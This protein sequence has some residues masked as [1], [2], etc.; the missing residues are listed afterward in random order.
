MMTPRSLPLF[1]LLSAI[2][3]ACGCCLSDERQQDASARDSREGLVRMEVEPL[4]FAD[5]TRTAMEVDEET[6]LHFTWSEGDKTGVYSSLG[7]FSLFRLESGA[8]TAVARFDGAGFD[9]SDGQTYRAFYPYS[10]AST[11]SEAIALDY[12]G[13]H[14]DS[15]DDRVSP[16]AY[17][18][19]YASAT[20]REGHAAFHFSHVGAFVRLRMT[21][22]EGLP[23][24][25]IDWVPMM[26]GLPGSGTFNLEDGRFTPDGA[27]VLF[28][29]TAGEG[30]TVPQGGVLTVWTVL[31]PADYT[32]ED[33]AVFVRSGTDI[34]FTAR[35]PGGRFASGKAARWSGAPLSL[36]AT[37]E[38]GWTVTDRG[39][40]TLSVTSG[41]YSGITWISGNRYAVVHDKL[42]GGGIT[43]F[44]IPISG[45]GTVGTVT[46]EKAPGTASAT[47]ASKDAEGIAWDGD[48]LFV[49][50]EKDQSISEYALE[51]LPTG[52]ALSIP[53]DM[54][55]AGLTSSNG[56][57]EALSYNAVTGR[58][59]TTTE[60]PLKKDSFLSRLHRLQSFNDELGPTQRYL[61][62]MDAPAKAS[63][64]SGATYVHGISALTALDDGRLVVL[65][66]EVYVPPRTG[67]ESIWELLSIASNAF[68]NT[69]LYLVD[70]SGDTAGIL[71]KSLLTSF[72]TNGFN[73]ANYEG[74]CLGPTLGD[75]SRCLVLI[76]DSQGGMGGLTSEYIR[77]VTLR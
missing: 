65:E 35:V 18:Y 21:L 72:S 43:F 64:E 73:L 46:M 61:Y 28:P 67:N 14:F 66:R 31:P 6:G 50:F 15:D 77:V 13:Q 76:P 22:P 68:A 36:D 58:F 75:G 70:P 48:H 44:T 45:N 38:H 8:G 7:G 32:A 69:K 19:L 56:G 25:G 17:D 42:K 54:G 63:V 24:S 16:M 62:R 74:M 40:K 53:A 49:S 47:T 10:A 55:K 59:W 41:Q 11:E 9:L 2:L 1:L 30:L 27:Q 26:D 39:Q 20:A 5:G 12:S 57:F 34:A 60:M 37:M 71:R 23:V 29:L 51:G 3:A 52:R 33:F 4:R